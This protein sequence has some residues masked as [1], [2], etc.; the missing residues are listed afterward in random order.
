MTS[1]DELLPDP[2]LPIG[3]FEMANIPRDKS[4]LPWVIQSHRDHHPIPHVHVKHPDGREA[5]VAIVDPQD[6]LEG[7]WLGGSDLTLVR[8]F[9]KLNQ[10]SL[11]KAWQDPEHH[12][13]ILSHIQRIY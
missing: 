1:I 10:E 12:V 3:L 5:S 13:E 6:R 8:R 4:G 11:L 7:E 2:N 9:I